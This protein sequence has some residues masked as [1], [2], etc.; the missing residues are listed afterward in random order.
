M[1]HSDMVDVLYYSIWDDVGRGLRA[2]EA[3][4]LSSRYEGI[5]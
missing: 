1:N 4:K 5:F 2:L 3:K